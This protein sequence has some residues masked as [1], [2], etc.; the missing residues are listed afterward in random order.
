M[1][2]NSEAQQVIEPTRSTWFWEINRRIHGSGGQERAMFAGISS[3]LSG[4]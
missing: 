1:P 4:V 2:A 3:D